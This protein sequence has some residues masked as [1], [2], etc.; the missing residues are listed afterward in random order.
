[1]LLTVLGISP[2][3]EEQGLLPR[4]SDAK[5]IFPYHSQYEEKEFWNCRLFST[6]LKANYKKHQETA[7]SLFLDATEGGSRALSFSVFKAELTEKRQHMKN[8]LEGTVWQQNARKTDCR[9]SGNG[10]CLN[11]V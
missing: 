6:L 2:K 9:M 4:S 7:N 5:G 3:K 11:R 10:D 8:S 1:M